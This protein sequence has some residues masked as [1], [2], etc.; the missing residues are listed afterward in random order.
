MRRH[1]SLQRGKILPA[2]A[3]DHL[4]KAR[5]DNQRQHSA[6]ASVADFLI[7]AYTS[8]CLPFD[9]LHISV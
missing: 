4:A 2:I 5:G 7:A 3:I 1:S 6:A 9:G 8:L